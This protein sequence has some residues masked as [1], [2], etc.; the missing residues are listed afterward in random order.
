MSIEYSGNDVSPFA[1]YSAQIG[2]DEE[3]P[4]D[5]GNSWQ[6][7]KCPSVIVGCQEVAF[8]VKDTE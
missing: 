6:R 4:S 2:V 7:R 8:V 5:Q 1:Y 3:M